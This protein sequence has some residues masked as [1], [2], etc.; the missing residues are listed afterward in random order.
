M[1]EQTSQIKWVA[2]VVNISP[3]LGK[4]HPYTFFE[5]DTVEESVHSFILETYHKFNID[6]VSQRVGKGYHYF[7]NN[8]DRQI[9]REWYGTIKHFNIKW[10]PLT[11]RITKKIPDEVFERPVYHEAQYVLLNWCRALMHFLNKEIRH[12]NSTNLH[13]AMNDCGLSKYFKCVL[14]K[15]EL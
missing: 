6:V 7:G 2:G 3:L 10:P 11:L 8:T 13:S 4:D 14:Y 9:W 1:S 15:V 12:E 5:V